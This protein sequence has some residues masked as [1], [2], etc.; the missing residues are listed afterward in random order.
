MAD[1]PQSPE[2]SSGVE[3]NETAEPTLASVLEAVST[4]SDALGELRTSHAD[5]SEG[6]S[7]YRKQTNADLA[8]LRRREAA[9]PAEAGNGSTTASSSAPT[10]LAAA[11]KLQTGLTGLPDDLVGELVERISS[12]ESAAGVLREVEAIRRGMSLGAAS[13]KSEESSRRSTMTPRDGANTGP[14]QPSSPRPRTRTEFGKLMKKD[15]AL[16][17]ALLRDETFKLET[18]PP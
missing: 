14:R 15:R 13:A 9:E 12:G 10:E 8:R 17:V 2:V 4:L 7:K 18:L 1:L 6:F 16:A 5:F 3:S 11:V